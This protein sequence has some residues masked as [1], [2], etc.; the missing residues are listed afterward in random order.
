M[1]LSRSFVAHFTI[2][3]YFYISLLNELI[4]QL[5]STFG[6]LSK[7][8][9]HSHTPHQ[10]WLS[11][12][13]ISRQCLN[14]E[15]SYP[16]MFMNFLKFLTELFLWRC[17]RICTSRVC[18]LA[19][20]RNWDAAKALK[21]NDERFYWG[22]LGADIYDCG[23]AHVHETKRASSTWQSYFQVLVFRFEVAE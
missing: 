14:P 6:F 1:W 21:A 5:G 19:S 22:C 9:T 2:K 16:F 15:C 17:C 3:H 12:H 23:W 13:T 10:L 7:L 18:E 11:P 4:A 20:I 8:S